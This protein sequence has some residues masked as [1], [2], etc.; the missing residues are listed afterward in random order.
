[1]KDLIEFI[2]RALVDDPAA[3]EVRERG[4]ET[5]LELRVADADF[6]NVVGR[7]GKTEHAIRTVLA[8]GARADGPVELT[9]VEPE[10]RPAE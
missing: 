1:M 9:I 8:A 2:A 6:G 10:E 7:Q 4:S 3:V 5:D